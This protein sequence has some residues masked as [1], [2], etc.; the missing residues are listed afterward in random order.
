MSI[1]LVAKELYL[2]QKLVEQLELELA[3][4]P[5]DRR[6]ACEDKLRKARAQRD[7]LRRVLDGK[8]GR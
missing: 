8:I 3:G 1:K 5:W 2:C 7:Y 6:A 4:L